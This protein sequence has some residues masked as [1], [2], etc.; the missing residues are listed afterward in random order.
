MRRVN[1]NFVFVAVAIVLGILASLS[2]MHYVQK[3]ADLAKARAE[4]RPKVA[5]VSVAVPVRSLNRGD[6][7]SDGDVAARD[8]PVD[9]VPADAITPDNYQNYIGSTLTMPLSKGVPI[10]GLAVESMANHFSSVIKPGDVAVTMQVDQL[11]SISG[12]IVPGDRIDILMTLSDSAANP[13]I[14]PLLSNVLV[15]ATGQRTRGVR[16]QAGQQANDLANYSDVTLELSPLDAQ[17][18]NVGRKVGELSVWLRRAG[19]DSSFELG[20]LTKAELLGYHTHRRGHG[21]Q[22]IIGGGG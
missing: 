14:R 10:P 22:F 4:N 17:R 9:L 18:L 7:L 5:T 3:Q 15:M 21:I 12:M 16:A 13:Q 19:S 11:N 8:V 6:V 20:A 2:A 1:R